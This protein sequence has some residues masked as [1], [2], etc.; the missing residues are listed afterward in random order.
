MAKGG[1]ADGLAEVPEVQQREPNPSFGLRTGRRF[2][3][4]QGLGLHQPR[5]RFGLPVRQRVQ[6]TYGRRIET[7]H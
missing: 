5:M 6:V 4:V 7:K 3:V 1:V 2:R